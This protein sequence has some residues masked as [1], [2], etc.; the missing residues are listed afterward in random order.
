MSNIEKSI[1]QIYYTYQAYK[2]HIIYELD[3][4]EQLIDEIKELS[5]L[6]NNIKEGE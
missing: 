1:M 4:K 5:Q 2:H 3:M 6:V